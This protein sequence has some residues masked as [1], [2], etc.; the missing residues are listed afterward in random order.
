MVVKVIEIFSSYIPARKEKLA[1]QTSNSTTPVHL[2]FY[3]NQLKFH[4]YVCID[5]WNFNILYMIFLIAAHLFLFFSETANQSPQEL[6][7]F[8]FLILEEVGC[9]PWIKLDVNGRGN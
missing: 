9:Y 3:C 6:P 1:T 2:H 7:I 5:A 8:P 4:I